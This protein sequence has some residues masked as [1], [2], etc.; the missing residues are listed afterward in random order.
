MVTKLYSHEFFNHI[1]SQHP[2]IQFTLK[3]DDQK[4][5]FID[6]QIERK[7]ST[8]TTLWKK[9]HNNQYINYKPHHHNRIKSGVIKCLAG[10]AEMICHPTRLPQEREPESW[11]PIQWLSHTCS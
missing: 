5:A 6:L 9:A 2:A 1:N 4:I 8:T 7:D 11:L 10:R 3:E